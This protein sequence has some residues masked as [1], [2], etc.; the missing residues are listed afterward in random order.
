MLQKLEHSHAQ[1]IRD[2]A[3]H[4]TGPKFLQIL[5]LWHN[6]NMSGFIFVIFEYNFK[7]WKITFPKKDS[8]YDF[9]IIT[10]I[11]QQHQ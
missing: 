7:D 11:F 6:N 3:S 10:I 9:V 2:E 8:Q 5:Q 4:V 1:A